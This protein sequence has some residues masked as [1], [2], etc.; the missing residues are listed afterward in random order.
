[1]RKWRWVDA[2]T[3]RSCI[4][5]GVLGASHATS[6]LG[7]IEL[8]E[9]QRDAAARLRAALARFGGA[10]LADEVGLGKTYTALAAV[11]DASAL[12]I[13]APASLIGMWRSALGRTSMHAHLISFE[14]LSRREPPVARYDAVVVDEAHHAR[15]PG[16]R[17]YERLA[18]LTWGARVLLLSATP[19]HNAAADLHALLALFL[20][21]RARRMTQADLAT[22]I[23]RRTHEDVAS[24]VAPRRAAPEWLELS[25]SDEG[26]DAVLAIP[27]P[28]PTREGGDAGALIMLSL[29]RAWGSTDAALHA[30]LNRRLARAESLADALERGRHPTRAEMRA[31]VAGDDAMQL[32]FAELVAS[33]VAVH[34]GQELLVAVRRHAHGVRRALSTVQAIGS[35]ADDQR[36]ELLRDV[37]RRHPGARIIAFSQFAESVRAMFRRLRRD[38]RVAAITAHGAWVAGGP[39]S[40]DEALAR[41]APR[42]TGA[43]APAGIEAIE[44]LIATDLLSEGLNLQDASVVVHL[45]LPWTAS[46]LAQRMGRVWRIGSGH[47]VV[48]EYAV[49]PPARADALLGIIE[50]LRAK[51][52]AARTAVGDVVLPLLASRLG[53]RGRAGAAGAWAPPPA[54]LGQQANA[55][56]GEPRPPV[57]T[58]AAPAVAE[59]LRCL[60]AA[61]RGDGDGRDAR[62]RTR[63]AALTA[64]AALPPFV[65]AVRAR[66]NGWLALVGI[67]AGTVDAR[68]VAAADGL[69]A[70][71]DPRAILDV[72]LSADGPTCAAAPSRVARALDQLDRFMAG[73]RASAATDLELVGSRAH[74]RVAGRIAIVA[75]AAPAHRRV[76]MSRLAARA[77][78]ALRATR[79]AGGERMLDALIPPGTAESSDAAGEAWLDRVIELG[80]RSLPNAGD[81]AHEAA[82]VPA[83]SPAVLALLMLV[84]SAD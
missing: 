31:W 5:T 69:P 75:A 48:H 21:S 49:A 38:P 51:S 82:E 9:H 30:A 18:A 3:V 14:A 53:V 24:G 72:A 74:A 16:T 25:A 35:A 76:I 42:A 80:S 40:R 29:I 55:P 79:A 6:R 58:P 26:L 32:A 39:L 61:W 65:G 63:D 67:A 41:F 64:D 56:D 28:C 68:I 77:R 12:L 15:N 70:T 78:T 44:L 71:S 62:D 57:V 59:R 36:A 27:A 17:R 45:D 46:R 8:R 22:C 2:A 37:R 13:V 52:V 83:E 33:E 23:V 20:G 73:E 19:V 4:A 60:L 84:A 66:A 34:D 1:M 10:L 81:S 11:R 54:S 50:R 7:E 47:D 43:R